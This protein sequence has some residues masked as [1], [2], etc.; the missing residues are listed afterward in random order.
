M[1]RALHISDALSLPLELVTE[2]VA[3][4]AVKR[5]GKSHTAKKL[6]E[7][8]HGA[9]QQIV[10]VD[11]KGDWWGLRSSADGKGPGLPIV[12]LGGEHSDVPLEPGSGELVAKLVV[13]QQVSLLLDLSELRKHQVA[14]FM[15][16]FLEALYRLKA[17]DIYRTPMMLVVDEADAIAPQRPQRGE[18]RMLGAAEDIVRRGGQRGIGIILVSQRAAVLNKNVLTQ[19]GVLILLRTTGSQDIDAVDDWIKKHGQQEK[20]EKVMASIAALPRGTGWVWAPGWPDERGIFKQVAISRCDTFDSGATPK[21]GERRLI[22]KTV[23]DV[24]LDAFRKEMAATIE[25]AKAEDPRELRRQLSEIKGELAK[26]KAALPSKGVTGKPII[27]EVKRIEVPVLKDAQIKRLEYLGGR[28]DAILR[29][30]DS[31]EKAFKARGEDLRAAAGEISATVRAKLVPEQSVIHTV[32]GVPRPTHTGVI[33]HLRPAQ[34]TA[35]QMLADPDTESLTP[36][37]QRILDG[38]AFLEGIGLAQGDKTQLALLADARPTSGAYFN[39]LGALR[40]A[41]LIDYPRPGLV[42]LTDAGRLVANAASAPATTEALHALLK[43]KLSPA[44][45]RLLEVLIAV[46]PKPLSKDDLA[47]R[48]GARETS[49]AYFNNLGSLRSLGLLDYPVPGS[50]VALPVLFLDR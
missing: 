5:A 50:V 46:Y 44:K 11:P 31:W 13:E 25:K 20:R 19:C 1:I 4:L 49:G 40:T 21:P 45:W 15:T 17:K 12:I 33:T 29:R 10:V 34:R 36:A 9:K 39:N 22:P 48:A 38:L 18:E 32:A 2:S 37:R 3:I 30:F 14:T 16:A 27:P 24:D 42:A 8:L 28:V 41:G 23:A 7:Q 35:G 26:A 6:V 47:T 43:A